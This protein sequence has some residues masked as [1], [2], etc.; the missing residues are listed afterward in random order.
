[1]S[2]V[3]PYVN[4]QLLIN[5][6]AFRAENTEFLRLFTEKDRTLCQDLDVINISTDEFLQL[7]RDQMAPTIKMLESKRGS[8]TIRTYLIKNLGFSGLGVDVAVDYLVEMRRNQVITDLIKKICIPTQQKEDKLRSLFNRPIDELMDLFERH[9]NYHQALEVSKKHGLALVDPRASWLKR[10]KMQKNVKRDR[11]EVVRHE[12]K[13]LRQIKRNVADLFANNRLL[14]DIVN[15]NWSF[16]EILALHH[17]YQKSLDKMKNINSANKI[18]IFEEV[19]AEF[20]HN[21]TEALTNGK[22]GLSLK[23]LRHLGENVYNL[24]LEVFDMD[25]TGR[26]RLMTELRTYSELVNERE[27][28]LL[29]QRDR[30]EFLSVNNYRD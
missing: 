15:K 29:T 1:M 28:L 26:N 12:K 10:H 7:F 25:N 17:Q 30:E 27:Q 9:H 5:R 20:R 11:R 23:E 2:D 14:S 4:S 19:T 3:D 6:E 18:E 24:L 8:K 22:D 13:S 21:N 16:V